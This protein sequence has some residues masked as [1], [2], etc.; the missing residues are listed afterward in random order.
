MA[1]D[2]DNLPPERA[3][4]DE[5]PSRLVWTV[6]FFVL[7]IAGIFGVMALWPRAEPMQTPLFWTCLVLYP[8][9][10]AAFVVSRRFSIHERQCLDA[11]DW[12]EARKRYNEKLF[13]RE[14]IPMAVLATAIRV[15]DDETAKLVTKIEENALTLE[16]QAS[17]LMED[18]SVTARWLQPDDALFAV[19]D[20]ERHGLLLSWLFDQ[21]IGEL[22]DRLGSLPDDFPLRVLLDIGGYIG[23]A[24]AKTTWEGI[25]AR[26]EL[27]QAETTYTLV[28]VDLMTVD[29]WLDDTSGALHLYAVLLI[30]VSLQSMLDGAPNAGEAE[31][32]VALLVASHGLA[33]E[34]R[35]MPV[36][37][38]HR[39]LNSAR[40][41]LDSALTHALQW[42]KADAPS[43]ESVWMTGF[44]G[45][46]VGPLHS[47]LS[48]VGVREAGEDPL[49]E[50]NLDGT[51]GRA[52]R[53]AD[54]LA[55]ACGA[56]R[57]DRLSAPQLVARSAGEHF[58]MAV[59]QNSRNKQKDE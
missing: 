51:V 59:V 38:M 11:R 5:P 57:A 19:D 37:H 33:A 17:E 58:H 14:S 53:S 25:W 22:A 26:H 23:E 2:L 9:G 39:P 29:Q 40:T 55:V 4:P 6:V 27:R 3:E 50:F 16:A 8:T 15:T 21:L 12:N 47:S 44:D 54:W 46:S 18:A 42:A 7:A 31:A 41:H 32:G 56:N 30:S 36:A 20:K 45:E 34:H 52:G 49:T 35:L 28:P 24:D 43:L 1:L 48:H 13:A 10:L